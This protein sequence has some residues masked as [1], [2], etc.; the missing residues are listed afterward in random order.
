MPRQSSFDIPKL[1][2]T[3][4]FIGH[5]V[6]HR[7]SFVPSG[8]PLLT[9]TLVRV[10]SPPQSRQHPLAGLWKGVRVQGRW[11]GGAGTAL[12]GNGAPNCLP[13]CCCWRHLFSV[14][15]RLQSLPQLYPVQPTLP[16]PHDPQGIY[17]VH[18]AEVISVQ[19]VFA[20][21]VA[22]IVGTKITGDRDVPAGEARG[23]DCIPSHQLT[24]PLV[25]FFCPGCDTISWAAIVGR[26][27]L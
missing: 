16:P 19:Y 8:V 5:L 3:R 20:G 6:A 1:L 21:N 9:H 17:G 25:F 10:R 22:R 13:P 26:Q 4:T 27:P 7:I 18:G 11:G 12:P 15:A 24:S 14:P 23:W 2:G